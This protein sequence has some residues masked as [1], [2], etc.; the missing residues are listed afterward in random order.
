MSCS[1]TLACKILDE[2]HGKRRQVVHSTKGMALGLSYDAATVCDTRK[3]HL[4][5]VLC[6]KFST[7]VQLMLE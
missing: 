5:A 7:Q 1:L 6:R 3:L 2:C 4:P